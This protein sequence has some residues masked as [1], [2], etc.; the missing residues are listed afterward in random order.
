MKHQEME[1]NHQVLERN[2][3]LQ[4]LHELC[5][6]GNLESMEIGSRMIFK[7]AVFLGANETVCLTLFALPTVALYFRFIRKRSSD[8]YLSVLVFAMFMFWFLL[9]NIMRQTLA[10]AIALQA[11]DP[12]MRK[13]RLK[14]VLIV[15]LASLV[16]ATAWPFLIVVFLISFRVKI[17]MYYLLALSSICVCILAAAP[18]VIQFAAVFMG[19][20]EY[21]RTSFMDA[22]TLFHPVFYFLILCCII[23]LLDQKHINEYDRMLIY[24]LSIGVLLY[25]ISIRVQIVGSS[26]KLGDRH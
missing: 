22:G 1:K 18:Y 13:K 23:I 15:F 24:M 19:Y 21:I 3:N 6:G 5:S 12:V 20:T 11:I 4:F 9:F 25:T 8:V 17:D 7:A 14:A 2:R 26:L 16:H 10:M